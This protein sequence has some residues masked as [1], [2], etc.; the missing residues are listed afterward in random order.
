MNFTKQQLR[1][2]NKLMF[3]SLL[4]LCSILAF[5]N[6]GMIAKTENN[7]MYKFLLG[8]FLV[9]GVIIGISYKIFSDDKK[10]MYLMAGTWIVMEVFGI[11]STGAWITYSVCFAIMLASVVYM[12]VKLTILIDLTSLAIIFSNLFYLIIL[13]QQEIIVDIVVVLVMM[14]IIIS[15]I[16]VAL[17]IVFKKYMGENRLSLQEK[18]DRQ[19]VI[20]KE[21][22]NASEE[23]ATI[24]K[25][26]NDDLYNIKEQVQKNKSFMK[27]LSESMDATAEEIQN[28]ALST[29]EI[30][31]IIRETEGHAELVKNTANSV[32]VTVNTGVE[33]SETVIEQSDKVNNYTNKMTEKMQVLSTKVN[34]VSSIVETILSISNQTNLLALNASIEAAR[35]GEAGRGFAVVAEEIRVLSEDTRVSTSKITDIISD[36]TE[37]ANETLNIL[38]E[39]VSSIKLQGESVNQMNKS[40]A[41]TGDD[42]SNLIKDLE[43]I[44]NDI[45]TLTT[46]NQII[47]D[48]ISQLSGT[49][50]EVTA[51]SQEGYQISENIQHRVD[52][53]NEL[54]EKVNKSILELETIVKK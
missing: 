34:D 25:T 43:Q 52:S 40:F 32:L 15:I 54:I 26:V 24:F 50:E 53:F 19:N 12:N 23:V 37:A 11:F 22:T 46:S 20:V 7:G 16:C 41:D 2:A 36:L 30:Q 5:T 1:R 48:A 13:K 9:S 47:V 49:T 14:S 21:V 3:I 51:V 45:N 44:Q 28:Q 42:V 33:L 8:L 31:N 6:V 27:D 39:S 17:T 18:I 38:T 4:V 35:A 29:N 10:A